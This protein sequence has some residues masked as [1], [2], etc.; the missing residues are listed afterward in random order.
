MVVRVCKAWSCEDGNAG[1]VRLFGAGCSGL[2]SRQGRLLRMP[3]ISRWKTYLFMGMLLARKQLW[4]VFSSAFALPHERAGGR[5]AGGVSGSHVRLRLPHMAMQ[6]GNGADGAAPEAALR[7]WGLEEGLH[8]RASD[9]SPGRRCLA[10]ARGPMLLAVYCVMCTSVSQGLHPAKW[11]SRS[12]QGACLNRPALIAGS[13]RATRTAAHTAAP[14]ACELWYC[15]CFSGV[16]GVSGSHRMARPGFSD[17]ESKAL[18]L[19]AGLE[20][21]GSNS[22][23]ASDAELFI[24]VDFGTAA[25]GK[26]QA[27]VRG[28]TALSAPD[29][30][31]PCLHRLARRRLRLHAAGAQCMRKDA[32][33]LA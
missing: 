23:A 12:E 7:A 18:L 13:S 26:S 21:R 2:I 32:R 9:G 27:S 29:S 10:P 1:E 25:T 15:H 16:S 11:G 6:H 33:A 24:G 5:A 8:L 31:R 22:S 30:R 3:S 14:V 17:R 20:Q 28:T 19:L 4:A